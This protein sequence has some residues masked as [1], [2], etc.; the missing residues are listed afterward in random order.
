M[1]FEFDEIVEPLR[2]ERQAAAHGVLLDWLVEADLH[3]A[4]RLF[5]TLEE[6]CSMLDRPQRTVIV[7]DGLAGLWAG[8]P[9]VRLK[10]DQLIGMSE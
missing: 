8:V 4:R 7:C 10:Y 5:V 3:A 1:L 6:H 9:L 2:E